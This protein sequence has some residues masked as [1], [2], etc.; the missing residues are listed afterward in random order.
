MK[1]SETVHNAFA[2]V[3][4]LTQQADIPNRLIKEVQRIEEAIKEQ[5]VAPG[6]IRTMKQLTES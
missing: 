4:E 2:P 1:W 6:G 3:Y 5:A